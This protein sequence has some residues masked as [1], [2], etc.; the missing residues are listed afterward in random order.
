MSLMAERLTTDPLGEEGPVGVQV[1]M[2]VWVRQA[3][4]EA[5]Y[6]VETT[7]PGYDF[8]ETFKEWFIAENQ[9]QVEQDAWPS[10]NEVTP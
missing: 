7:E 3:D 1:T 2:M 6:S 10:L 4:W 5:E 9:E 8:E